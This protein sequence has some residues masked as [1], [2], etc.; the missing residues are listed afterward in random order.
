[1]T[2]QGFNALRRQGAEFKWT[3]ELEKDFIKLKEDF[4]INN[5]SSFPIYN[6]DKPF[7]LT[8]N[9]SALALGVT[10]S[11][12]Q[13]GRDQLIAAAGTRTTPGE[14]IMLPGR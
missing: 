8:I 13:N 12:A 4:K 9:F 7:I 3:P 6:S 11:H 14:K 5:T 10:L 2:S 1:M